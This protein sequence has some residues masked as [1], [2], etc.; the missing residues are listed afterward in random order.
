MTTIN[1]RYALIKSIGTG[2]MADVYLADDLIL[3]RKIA[4]KMIRVDLANDPISLLRFK[5]EAKAISKMDH[6]NIVQVYDVGEY[7]HRPYI[8]MEYVAGVTL[9]QLLQKRIALPLDEVIDIMKQLTAAII[10]AHDNNIVHRDIKPHNV[11]IKDDGTAKI[12]DFGIALSHDS[13]Q[14]T[15]SDTVLGSA[16][17]LAPEITNGEEASKQSDIYA[18]GIVFYELLLGELPFNGNTPV[19]VAMAH[20]NDLLPNI[21]Q[22]NSSIPLAIQH[23]IQKACEKDLSKRYSSA[24]Q[25]YEALENWQSIQLEHKMDDKKINNKLPWIVGAISIGVAVIYCVI[26]LLFNQ[27]STVNEKIMIPNVLG[28]S[29]EEATEILKMNNL[30]VVV[31]T[32]EIESDV[33]MGGLVA[34]SVP[35]YNTLVDKN[36][37]VEITVSKGRTIK[38]N[39]F[40]DKHIDE[41]YQYIAS[42]KIQITIEE[43]LV[44]S[45]K[46][47]GTVL[48][49]SIAPNTPTVL[50]SE[51]K[52]IVEVAKTPKKVMIPKVIGLSLTEAKKQLEALGLKVVVEG[53]GNVATQSMTPYSVID[54]I[55]EEITLEGN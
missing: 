14:I 38:I 35:N 55:D 6:Q 37:T 41:V 7:N 3:G 27:K 15:A 5:R 19:Q 23:I 40:V 53:E 2:G 46:Q 10:H 4:L 51:S 20:I 29:K 12:T 32:N 36:A 30:N 54:L 16:H 13:M 26:L 39:N 8:V 44:P 25:L 42:N 11:L 17:Y 48:S 34:T 33:Y 45:K 24:K 43:K 50:T 47:A 28:K 9:K 1:E 49:Q 52:L 18:L 31:S 22:K 21:T